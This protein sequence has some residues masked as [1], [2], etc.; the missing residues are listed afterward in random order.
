MAEPPKPN[1]THPL[2]G[3]ESEAHDWTAAAGASHRFLAV[4]IAE[5]LNLNACPERVVIVETHHS[6]RSWAIVAAVTVRGEVQRIRRA[7]WVYTLT[8]G[9]TRCRWQ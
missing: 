5:K 2:S 7:G 6:H 8:G 4:V 3:T 1:I 9:A